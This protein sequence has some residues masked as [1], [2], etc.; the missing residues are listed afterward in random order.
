G[1]GLTNA[2]VVVTVLLMT[3]YTAYALLQIRDLNRPV[4]AGGIDGRAQVLAARLNAEAS[5]LNAAL[6]SAAQLADRAP[7]RPIEAVETGLA[8]AGSSARAMA[9][10]G[11]DGLIAQSGEAAG[12]NWLAA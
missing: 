5:T 9:I 12:A 4:E 10:M 3:L 2:L 11:A 6:T 7:D 8:I 1:G